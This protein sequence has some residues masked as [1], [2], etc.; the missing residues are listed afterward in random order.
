MFEVEGAVKDALM[1][2]SCVTDDVEIL[3]E[4]VASD[5]DVVFEAG[6]LTTLLVVA[7]FVAL[8]V[9]LLL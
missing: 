3:A 6:E 7:V 2:L 8:L 4:T 5:F 1:V 9:L